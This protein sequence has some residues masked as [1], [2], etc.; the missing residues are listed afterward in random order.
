MNSIPKYLSIADTCRTF[1]IGK[2]V[3]YRLIGEGRI[4]AR[5]AGA[6]TLIDAET[7][8]TWASSL[9]AANIGRPAKPVVS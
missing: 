6:K 4:V 3:L 2:T 8:A 1:G 5:K 9:P 7:A